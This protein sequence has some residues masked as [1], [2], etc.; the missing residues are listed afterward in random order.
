MENEPAAY[1]EFGRFL[2]E[3]YRKFAN[4]MWTIG[5]DHDPQDR[6]SRLD[7]LANGLKDA[8]PEFILSAH[9]WENK[10]AMDQY[11][12]FDWLDL[13][14][15]YTYFPE[16]NAN[17]QVYALSLKEY[18][19][20]PEKPFVMIESGYENGVTGEISVAPYQV[21]REAYWSILSGS[22]GFA[23]GNSDIWPFNPRWKVALDDPGA[24]YQM[25]A[26][27]VFS[28]Y[29]WFDLVPD[30]D[31]NIVIE[32]YGTFNQDTSPGG[33]EYITAAGTADGLLAIIYIPSTGTDSRAFYINMSCFSSSFVEAKW[34]NPTDGSSKPIGN[35]QCTE[36]KQLF[37][38]PGDNGTSTNDWLLTLTRAGATLNNKSI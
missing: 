12:Q 26:F 20:R 8:N 25:H 22:T 19:R 10:S 13:N 9:T 17:T 24:F 34:Y 21:R 16:W 6:I 33:D 32:G 7:A 15:V 28:S 29:R 2:G 37:T 35:F 27:H 11:G 36:R 1:R 4:I 3:R 31:H 5:G 14:T 18:G 23:Y 38:T 30:Q